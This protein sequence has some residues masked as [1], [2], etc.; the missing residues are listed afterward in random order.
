MSFFVI[1]SSDLG[2]SFVWF[3]IEEV[4]SPCCVLGVFNVFLEWAEMD[5][6]VWQFSFWW[7]SFPG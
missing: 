5:K 4:Y 3:C 7:I 2:S 1:G 6:K